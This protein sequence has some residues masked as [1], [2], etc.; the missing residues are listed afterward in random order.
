M[1]KHSVNLER[2]TF[3]ATSIAPQTMTVFRLPAAL[4]GSLFDR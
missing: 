1:S 2:T 3:V 4:G